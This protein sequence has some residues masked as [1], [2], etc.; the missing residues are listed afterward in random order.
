MRHHPQSHP[1]SHPIPTSA[2]MAQKP[3]PNPPSRPRI[4]RCILRPQSEVLLLNKIV[5]TPYHNITEPTRPRHPPNSLLLLRC[6]PRAVTPYLYTCPVPIP[7]RDRR[8]HQLFALV[9]LYKLSRPTHPLPLPGTASLG[10][11]SEVPWLNRTSHLPPSRAQNERQNRPRLRELV[12]RLSLH[13]G[14][15]LRPGTTSEMLWP[16]RCR[17][18]V[19]QY[20]GRGTWTTRSAPILPSRLA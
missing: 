12:T 2:N 10:A 16:G 11:L 13:R 15:G 3:N 9:A 7:K 19:S 14:P 5:T 4:S 6:Q 20:P 8:Y 18:A 17:L 1:R